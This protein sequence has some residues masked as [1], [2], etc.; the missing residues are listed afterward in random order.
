[1]DPSLFS[2]QHN[3]VQNK[4]KDGKRS[5]DPQVKDVKRWKRRDQRR[6]MRCERDV[7]ADEDGQT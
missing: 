6:A 2:K 4:C 5:V 1:M 7:V 3:F